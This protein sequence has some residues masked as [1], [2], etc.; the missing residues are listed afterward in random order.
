MLSK[1]SVTLAVVAATIMS[2]PSFAKSYKFK[3]LDYKKTDNTIL[4]EINKSGT[5]VGNY[6]TAKGKENC[7]IVTGSKKKPLNNPAEK[8]TVCGGINTA[9]DIVGYYPSNNAQGGKAFLYSN[10][11]FTDVKPPGSSGGAIAYGINDAGTIIGTYV[12]ANGA[13]HGFIKSGT[14]YTSYDIP[15]QSIT[16][17]VSINNSGDYTSQTADANGNEHSFIY[18]GGAYTELL[19]PNATSTRAHQINNADVVAIGW[20]DSSGNENGGIYEN[21]TG[22]YIVE[23]DPLGAITGV[24]GIN[25][26]DTLVGIFAKPTDTV[27]EGFVAKGKP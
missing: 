13:Q 6:I 2:T 24:E 27:Y 25:D 26:A 1:P 5:I 9:G 4:E 3:T 20:I 12:D 18:A 21:A 15:G 14:T 10:G 7:F 8:S 11:A 19:F 23:N 16:I 17:G 22:A